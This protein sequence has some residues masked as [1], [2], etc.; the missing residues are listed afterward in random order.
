MAGDV[1][2]AL[3][4]ERPEVLWFGFLFRGSFIKAQPKSHRTCMRM[5]A[6]V[7]RVETMYG[8]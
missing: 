7:R 4:P 8:W 3:G 6:G 5:Y 2:S 1:T